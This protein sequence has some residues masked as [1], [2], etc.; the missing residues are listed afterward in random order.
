MEE[1]WYQTSTAGKNYI[2][3]NEQELDEILDFKKSEN[4]VQEAIAVDELFRY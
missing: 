3:I 2:E 1:G 4:I